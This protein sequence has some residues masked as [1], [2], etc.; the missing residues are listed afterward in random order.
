LKNYTHIWVKGI[1]SDAAAVRTVVFVDEQGFP[2]EVELDELDKTALHIVLYADNV[3]I[4]TGR[5]LCE[6]A[7]IFRLG[8]IA[9]LRELRGTGVGFRIMQLME[10]K[11]KSLNGEKT[12]LS[13]QTHSKGFYE[14]CGYFVV[15][16]EYMDHHVAHVDMEKY[17]K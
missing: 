11:V 8:R 2:A 15:G 17:I 5:V 12:V 10:E 1:P 14:K 6:S 16:D 9:V 7:N 4:A 13:A 3:P